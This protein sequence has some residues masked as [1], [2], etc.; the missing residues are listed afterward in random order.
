MA[1]LVDILHTLA[2][3]RGRGNA[4][5]LIG[6]HRLPPRVDEPISHLPIGQ[7]LIE[8][9]ITWTGQPFRRHHSLALS[10]LRR[11]EAVALRAGGTAARHTLHL[12]TLELQRL[13]P[14]STALVVTPDAATQAL[15]LAELNQLGAAIGR[16]AIALPDRRREALTAPIV[17]TTPNA[18]HDRLLRHHDRSWT[19]LWSRLR[20]LVIADATH[21]HGIAASHLAALILRTQRLASVPLQLLAGIADV[22][23]AEAA[24]H[25]MAPQPWRMISAADSAIPER[26]LAIWRA[27]GERRQEAAALA[28]ALQRAGARV[29]VLGVALDLPAIGELIGD[30]PEI[31]VAAVILPADVQIVVGA[32]LG[33]VAIQQ[34]LDADSPLT[35]LLLGD[36]PLDRALVRIAL[37]EQALPQFMQ[38]PHWIF[39]PQNAYVVAQHLLCAAS[40]RPLSSAEVQ[41]WGFESI[42]DRLEDRGELLRLP[43]VQPFWQPASGGDDPYDGVAPVAAGS[44]P[45][46]VYDSQS[47]QPLALDPALFDRWAFLGAALPPLRGGLRVIERTDTELTLRVRME[48]EQRRTLPLRRCHVR[49]RDTQERRE[50]AGCAIGWGRV[51][52]DE[53]VY[54]YR[55][56]TAGNA[57]IDRALSPTL[58]GSWSAPAAWID[59]PAAVKATGQLA[60][61]SLAAALPL[62]SLATLADLVPAYDVEARRLFFVDAQPG[63][64]GLAIWLFNHLH[65]L[66]PTAY[67]I[68]LDAR[69][70]PLL[71]PA[72]RAD[73]D[74]LLPLLSTRP[75]QPVVLPIRTP[76]PEAVSPRDERP[77]AR[78]T[79]P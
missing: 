75:A 57:P 61:W 60:G 28:L 41:A 48:S 39:P 21:Y 76:Q 7:R 13:E 26:T 50:L 3:Q 33:S 79:P 16:P 24:L 32:A 10:A 51:L 46:L 69:N 55:E 59:L 43:D 35:I 27:N 64:S 4:T 71:E 65:Q 67:D 77:A 23:D 15:Y 36:D 19:A 37:H 62:H 72:A 8:G 74:W 66:L 38:P 58:H 18:L 34:A 11:G 1:D 9:W 54:G 68:A 44:P 29:H 6:M 14:Q 20:L 17:V 12:L 52:I 22:A 25:Q 42:V 5:P 45:A 56:I 73:M 78:E 31:T 2:R 53:E 47:S 40:E 63:G 30:L 49:V 70:D